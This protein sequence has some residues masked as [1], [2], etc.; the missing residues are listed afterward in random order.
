MSTTS[1]TGRNWRRGS[2]ILRP[3]SAAAGTAKHRCRRRRGH[4]T[5]NTDLQRRP[6]RP[7]ARA[8]PPRLVVCFHL[9]WCGCVRVGGRASPLRKLHIAQPATARQL[10]MAA[11]PSWA[12]RIGACT[13]YG[14]H[15]TLRYVAAPLPTSA[16]AVEARWKLPRADHHVHGSR[17]CVHGRRCHRAAVACCYGFE[18][19]GMP[20]HNANRPSLNMAPTRQAPHAV[21]ARSP[22]GRNRRCALRRCRHGS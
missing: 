18:N 21:L 4:A 3:P 22:A 11:Q 15:G 16:L 6:F 12:I 8:L 20:C 7:R 9:A 13:W 19:Y 10:R 17:E 1:T 14:G 5:Q 2:R